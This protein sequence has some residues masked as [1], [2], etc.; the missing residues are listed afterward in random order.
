MSTIQYDFRDGDTLSAIKVNIF[1]KQTKVSVPLFA[2]FTAEIKWSIDNAATQTRAMN[3]LSG[4]DDGSVLYQFTAGE[5]L[6]GTMLIQVRIIE[7][8]TGFDATTVNDICKRI[9]PSL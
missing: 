8:G 9:G 4:N 5:L 3:V 2:S 6:V 7:N 1:D